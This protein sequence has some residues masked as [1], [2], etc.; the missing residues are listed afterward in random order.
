MTSADGSN[1]SSKLLLN[2]LLERYNAGAKTLVMNREE[3]KIVIKL[4]QIKDVIEVGGGLA[5]E[6]VKKHMN[7]NECITGNNKVNGL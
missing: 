2:C 1:S 4:L 5:S 6:R 3:A 7:S